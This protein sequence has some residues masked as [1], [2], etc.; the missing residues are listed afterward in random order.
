MVASLACRGGVRTFGA[1]CGCRASLACFIGTLAAVPGSVAMLA[2]RLPASRAFAVLF[3][4]RF[5]DLDN[6]RLLSAGQPGH[7]IKSLPCLA[8]RF[9]GA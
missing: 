4:H 2:H 9:C 3:D 5:H 1:A 6:F 8:R 7:R